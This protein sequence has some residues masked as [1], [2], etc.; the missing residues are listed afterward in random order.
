MKYFT[1][2]LY[3]KDFHGVILFVVMKQHTACI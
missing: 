3:V 1:I 2:H